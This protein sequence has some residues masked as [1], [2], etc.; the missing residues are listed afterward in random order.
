MHAQNTRRERRQ[1]REKIKYLHPNIKGVSFLI[2][3]PNIYPEC[4]VKRDRCD[5]YIVHPSLKLHL[6]KSEVVLVSVYY[7]G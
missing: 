4:C 5:G 7:S 6:L 3:T 1:K 2:F